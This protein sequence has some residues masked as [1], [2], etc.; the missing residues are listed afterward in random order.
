M[1]T[2][3][4][5]VSQ[6]SNWKLL[7]QI[8]SQNAKYEKVISNYI[9]IELEYRTNINIIFVIKKILYALMM[10]SHDLLFKK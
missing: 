5:T 9:H 1:V 8:V 6:Y 4:S 3:G 2:T 10:L 7:F